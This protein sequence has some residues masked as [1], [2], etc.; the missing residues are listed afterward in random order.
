MSAKILVVDDS[1]TALRLTRD[2]LAEKGFE[3]LTAVD[4]DDALE[5]ANRE[6]PA[7]VVLDIVLPKKNGFQVCRKLKTDPATSAMKVIL[8]SSKKEENDRQWGLRQGADGYVTKPY[9]LDEL[10]ADIDRILGEAAPN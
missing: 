3:A 10:V 2:A 1:P 8:L 4:G 7:L 9:D 5:V 6:H